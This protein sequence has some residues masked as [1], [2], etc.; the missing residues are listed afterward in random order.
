[1]EDSRKGR[2][3]RHQTATN[4][5]GRDRVWF[6]Q[7]GQVTLLQLFRWWAL[8]DSNLRPRACEA[9]ALTS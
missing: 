5:D 2:R 3:N 1:M 7:T 8:E 4:T 6:S 9:R